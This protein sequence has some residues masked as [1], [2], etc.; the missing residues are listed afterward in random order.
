M[1]GKMIIP[2]LL[3]QGRPYYEAEYYYNSLDGNYPTGWYFQTKYWAAQTFTPQKDYDLVRVEVYGRQNDSDDTYKI[4]IET[5]DGL[6]RPSGTVL[7]THYLYIPTQAAYAWWGFDVTP[8]L[9][10]VNG[11]TYAIVMEITSTTPVFFIYWMWALHVLNPYPRGQGW[12][13]TDPSAGWTGAP[14]SSDF[15]FITYEPA[16]GD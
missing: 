9:G 15:F 3:W 16:P 1:T 2:W 10:L 8:G 7:H 5:V 13:T 4:T 14:S 12:V 11:T 6:G